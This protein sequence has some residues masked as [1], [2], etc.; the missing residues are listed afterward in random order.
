MPT[1]QEM[2]SVRRNKHISGNKLDDVQLSSLSSSS[3]STPKNPD[4]LLDSSQPN[5]MRSSLLV[6]TTNSFSVAYDMSLID[7]DMSGYPSKVPAANE[8]GL[9]DRR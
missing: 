2:E 9:G 1:G 5:V 8:T 3:A 4:S 7:L 6:D